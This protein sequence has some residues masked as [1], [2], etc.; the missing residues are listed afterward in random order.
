LVQHVCTSAEAAITPAV[1]DTNLSAGWQR[2]LRLSGVRLR[3]V[4]VNVYA[5]LMHRRESQRLHIADASEANHRDRHGLRFVLYGVECKH[6]FA[7]MEL[8][9]DR[10]RFRAFVVPVKETR[11]RREVDRYIRNT[12]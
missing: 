2:E 3:H 9:C 7:C 11:S 8:K 4:E 1:H 6:V 12:P 5:S 10:R